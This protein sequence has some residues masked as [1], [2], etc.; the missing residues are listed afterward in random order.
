ML[1]AMYSDANAFASCV[2]NPK[3]NYGFPKSQFAELYKP[4]DGNSL[5]KLLYKIRSIWVCE[6]VDTCQTVELK[7]SD[8]YI[9]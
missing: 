1:T 9:L 6:L 8:F 3:A 2:P 4:L 5:V 7:E